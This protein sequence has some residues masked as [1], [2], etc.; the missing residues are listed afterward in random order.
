[1]LL[2][3]CKYFGTPCYDFSQLFPAKYTERIV[4]A[5]GSTIVDIDIVSAE[6]LFFICLIKLN[7]YSFNSV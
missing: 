5:N 6:C 2:L 4:T 7:T 1:M 3:S